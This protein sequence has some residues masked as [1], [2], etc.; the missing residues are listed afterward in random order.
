M[1]KYLNELKNC[2]LFNGI[3]DE[4]LPAMLSCLGARV[5]EV[6]KNQIIFEEGSDAKTIGVVLSG[7]V[8]LVQD[9]YYGNRSIVALISP[10][11]L[12]GE[13]FACARVE[14]LPVSMTASADG[15]VLL[16]DFS[17]IVTTCSNACQ[18]HSRMIFNLLRLVA[19]KNLVFNQKIEITSRRTT[20]EKLMTYLMYQAKLN[21]SS[22]FTIPYDRQ[23]L[24]D[25]L[26]VERSALSAEI[27]RLRAEGI[28]ESRKSEFTIL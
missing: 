25:Y 20:R 28:I 26:G 5:A 4:D 8:Q 27:S 19:E 12:F 11:E 6:E 24:A 3:S 17:R 16:L 18:F 15:R 13:S 1:K 7:S 22:S 9:D 14:S 2:A 21:K 23:G 10:G